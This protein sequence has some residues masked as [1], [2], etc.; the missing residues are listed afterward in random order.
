MCRKGVSRNKRISHLAKGDV[1]FLRVRLTGSL[2]LSI[3]QTQ[4]AK[5]EN[6][7]FWNDFVIFCVSIDKHKKDIFFQD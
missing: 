7:P 2:G 4:Q 5:A 1:P 6:S 3:W